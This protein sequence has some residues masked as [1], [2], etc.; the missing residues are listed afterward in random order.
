MVAQLA[1]AADGEG[2]RGEIVGIGGL[3][4]APGVTYGQLGGGVG[5]TVGRNSLVFLETSY[6]PEGGGDKLVSFMGGLNIGF[7]TSIDK[8]VPYVAVVGGLGRDSDGH[9]ATNSAAFGAGFGARYYIGTNW[10]FRPEFRWQRY[11]RSGGGVNSYIFTAGLFYR[12]GSK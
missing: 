2:Y 10:G 1:R 11:Q 9:G 8:L 5:S 3:Q 4:H 7:A 12:F 6:T